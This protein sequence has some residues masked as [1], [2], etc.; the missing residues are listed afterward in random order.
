M[1]K[2]PFCALLPLNPDNWHGTFTARF[3]QLW[4]TDFRRLTRASALSAERDAEDLDLR[5]IRKRGAQ[6]WVLRRALAVSR[7]L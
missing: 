3:E 7:A 2:R 5:Q 6:A 1:F 4:I